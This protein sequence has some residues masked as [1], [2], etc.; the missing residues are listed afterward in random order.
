MEEHGGTHNHEPSL[1]DI[2]NVLSLL[3]PDKIPPYDGNCSFDLIEF[4]QKKASSFLEPTEDEKE[5]VLGMY[6]IF[7]KYA[8]DYAAL[9]TF[10][11]AYSQEKCMRMDYFE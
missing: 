11:F 9:C 10:S 4:M 3:L 1:G 2:E 8:W 5:K 7:E 6:K